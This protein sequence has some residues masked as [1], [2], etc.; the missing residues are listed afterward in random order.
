VKPHILLAAGLAAD[1]SSPA[2][3]RP[4]WDNVA[5]F[6]VGVEK[7][8][9]TL[10]VYPTA[11]LARTADPARSPWYKSLNGTWKF[12]LSPRPADRTDRRLHLAPT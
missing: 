9:T 3:E 4:E 5:V 10:M 7:P 11:D 2:Q 6:K 12:H 1:L 8:H